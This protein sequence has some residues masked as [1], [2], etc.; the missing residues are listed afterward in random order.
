MK[1]S[2]KN[3]VAHNHRILIVLVMS[4]LVFCC[5]A[6]SSANVVTKKFC[7]SGTSDGVGWS[8]GII[9]DTDLACKGTGLGPVDP[10]NGI[11]DPAEFAT[12]F[13][14][15]INANGGGLGY[16]AAVDPKNPHCFTITH[17]TEPG[18]PAN[19]EFWVGDAAGTPTS[20][21]QVTNNP[22]GC[23]FN[24]DIVEVLGQSI[25]TLSE[26]GMIIFSILLVGWMG[27]TIMRRRQNVSVGV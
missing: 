25:P 19:F 2:G 18:A 13:V 14:N 24:P 15:S 8:W 22:A 5:A 7:I 12:A 26:W 3:I 11:S 4:I 23:A 27:I 9:F 6:F 10:N 17:T 1:S 16:S 20:G 21:C